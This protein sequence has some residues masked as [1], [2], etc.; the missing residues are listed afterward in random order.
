M[1]YSL[2]ETV[3]MYVHL[4]K[5]SIF[6]CRVI[7]IRLSG[8]NSKVETMHYGSV[9]TF[10]V[11]P[12]AG[13]TI[14]WPHFV[15]HCDCRGDVTTQQVSLALGVVGSGAHAGQIQSVAQHGVHPAEDVRVAT[16][17]QGRRV[18][19]GTGR[20]TGVVSLCR[21]Q[22]IHLVL[23]LVQEEYQLW[24]GGQTRRFRT[25]TEHSMTLSA[26]QPEDKGFGNTKAPIITF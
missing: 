14:K 25:L 13:F 16:R 26:R 2:A 12:R 6:P 10:T 9:S 3:K 17:R 24:L 5:R 19:V 20:P 11:K 23:V 22:A 7:Q 15:S 4:V 18:R 1:Y 8:A 21:T